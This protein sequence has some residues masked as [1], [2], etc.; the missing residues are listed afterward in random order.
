[1]LNSL[2]LALVLQ[3]HASVY[4]VKPKLDVPVTLAGAAALI[5]PYA[6]A[7]R[8][9]TPRCP[10]DPRGVNAFDRP[11]IGNHSAIAKSLSDLTV[12]TVLVAPLAIDMLALGRSRPWL[13]DAVV[14]GQT[15]VV[16]G[17]LVTA[18]KFIVQRPLPRT[19]SGD[20]NMKIG[21]AHV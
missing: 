1:M 9:I 11:A 10:C 12:A 17:A 19:Y 20:P 4:H 6:Y 2:A 14:F 8:L 16:N 5:L 13:D 18:A 21:R 15:L 3:A 7:D